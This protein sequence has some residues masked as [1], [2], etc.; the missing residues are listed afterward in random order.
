MRVGVHV[1][2]RLPDEQAK[3]QHDAPSDFPI[4]PCQR[5]A[6][7]RE[8]RESNATSVTLAPDNGRKFEIG[9]H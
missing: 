4:E 2:A 7:L 5:G 8:G 1:R 6:H 9:E 3:G